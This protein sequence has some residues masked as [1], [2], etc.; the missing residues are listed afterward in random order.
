MI[1]EREA[2]LLHYVER[3]ATAFD[4]R[5]ID[6]G[7]FEGLKTAIADAK[8]FAAHVRHVEGIPDTMGAGWNRPAPATTEDL[9]GVLDDALT[10]VVAGDSFEGTITWEMPTGEPEL[11]GFDFGLIARYRVGNLDGQGG[12]R[13]YTPRS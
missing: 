8:S 7:L 3:I 12:L 1:R 5:T 13:V 11:E 2:V 9:A 10:R 4:A 6:A